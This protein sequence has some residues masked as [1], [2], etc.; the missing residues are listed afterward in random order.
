MSDDFDLTDAL[1]TFMEEGKELLNVMEGILLELEHVEPSTEKLNELFRTAHTLK[2]SAGLFSLDHIVQFAH[3]V[4]TFL[5]RVRSGD[6]SLTPASVQLLLE[7]NDQLVTLLRAAE[8]AT[9]PSQETLEHGEHLARRLDAGSAVP[10]GSDDKAPV[11]QATH[12][13]QRTGEGEVERMISSLTGDRES[14]DWHI[15]LRFGIDTFRAGMDPLSFIRYLKQLGEIVGLE[16]VTDRIPQASD[17]D[18]EDCYLG[19]EIRFRGEASK[20]DIENVFEFVQDDCEIR[21]VPASGKT[22]SFIDLIQALPEDDMRLGQIL[23]RVGTITQRELRDALDRQQASAQHEPIGEVLVKQGAVSAPLVEEALRKQSPSGNARHGNGRMLR[24]QASKLD[25]LIDNVGELVIASSAVAELAS[26]QNDPSQTQAASEVARLV[27]IIR[28]NALRLRMVEIRDC[29]RR[30]HRTVRDVGRELGKDVRLAL[31]G[32]D[33]EVDR[34]VVEKISDPL[35]HMIR[36][37]IDHGIEPSDERAAM[38]K[39][40]HGTVWLKA[41]HDTG[42]VV[43]EIADDGRGLDADKIRRRAESRGLIREDDQLGE[44]D[45]YQ[46][47]FHPGFSTAE[48]ISELSG[49]GVG[50]D[51]VKNVVEGLRGE[52]DVESVPER[53]TLVRIRLPLS[54]AI[55]DG[56][57]VRA[58]EAKY[59]VPLES[60]VECVDYGTQSDETIAKSYTKLRDSALPTLRLSDFFENFAMNSKR[61]GLLVVQ[62]EGERTGLIVDELL[63]QIEA[64]VKPLG[65]LFD[66]LKGIVGSTILGSG[67]LALILDIPRLMEI[68]T[69]LE[70]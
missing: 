33:T 23:E 5:D 55:M 45:L 68:A 70:G 24:I 29:F 1:A 6:E 30:Y 62:A 57:L 65:V 43:V 67:E 60:V 66:H 49:R 42:N 48:Q 19:F 46:L 18:P 20:Q 53:G 14:W 10:T 32:E 63:G 22:E 59:I 39:S 31:E 34:T 69:D 16:A 56:F 36:N 7:C 13:G 38:G 12:G 15:S 41:Y 37:A 51:V 58:G 28:E 26:R 54:L 9:E 2:G 27:S 17:L 64:V 52:I 8:E 35:L 40:S 44:K 47:I 50:M 4:E 21:L 61:S 11:A 25:T 3:V